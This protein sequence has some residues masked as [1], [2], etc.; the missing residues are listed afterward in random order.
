MIG[1]T[2]AHCG[3][4]CRVRLEAEGP[5]TEELVAMR[6]GATGLRSQAPELSLRRPG[7]GDGAGRVREGE[8]ERLRRV[9]EGVEWRKPRACD[10]PAP[11]P[12][13]PGWWPVASVGVP[14]VRPDPRPERPARLLGGVCRCVTFK[15]K[16]IMVGFVG[17]KTS[18][19]RAVLGDGVLAASGPCSRG[20]RPGQR[21]LLLLFICVRSAP[22]C[23]SRASS[24]ADKCR[25]PPEMT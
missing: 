23:F 11:E 12:E 17:E 20:R 4:Q 14:D 9:E 3:A 6:G 10:L 13:E 18:R 19:G 25:P 24:S 5:I 7:V 21:L 22:H 16:K 8:S 15:K 1:V 2:A